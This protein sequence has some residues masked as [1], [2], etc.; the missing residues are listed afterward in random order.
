[1]P[2]V[3]PSNIIINFPNALKMHV[4]KATS[5]VDNIKYSCYNGNIYNEVGEQVEGFENPIE[6]QDEVKH[7]VGGAFWSFEFF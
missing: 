2:P 6:L 7:I 5:L 1:M 4:T 3:I